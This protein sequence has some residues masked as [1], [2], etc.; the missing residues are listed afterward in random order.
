MTLLMNVLRFYFKYHSWS[1]SLD[2]YLEVSMLLFQ[3]VG[4]GREVI[5]VWNAYEILDVYLDFS[6]F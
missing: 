4:S 2:F 3:E 6:L 5:E 1:I